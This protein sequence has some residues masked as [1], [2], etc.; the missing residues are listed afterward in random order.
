MNK[1]HTG[2]TLS[3]EDLRKWYQKME[4]E[5]ILSSYTFPAKPSSDGYYHVYLSDAGGRKQI[6][7]K[8]LEK[9]KE[10]VYEYE[11][12][13]I[14]STRKTFKDVF[15]TVQQEKLRYVKDPEK[16]ISVGNT[17]SVDRS[18]YNRFFNGTEF[19]NMYID[20]ISKSDIEKL[21]FTTLEQNDLKKKAFMSMRNILSSVFKLAFEQYWILDNPYKRIDFKKY[22]YMLARD[23]A[24]HLRVHSSEDVERMLDFLHE[25]QSKKPGYIPAYALE[26]QIIM[27]LRRGEVAPIMWSDISSNSIRI[28]K[29]QI[30][31]KTNKDLVIVYHT[32]TYKDRE[33]PITSDISDFIDRLRAACDRFYPAS[34]YLFPD[35]SQKNGVISNKVVYRLYERMCKKLDIEISREFTRGPHSFRRNGITRICNASGGN[36]YLASVLYGNSPQSASRHYYTGINLS[37]A[38]A[39]LEGNRKSNPRREEHTAS[40]KQDIRKGNHRVTKGN[41]KLG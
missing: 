8:N 5:Q 34:P 1:N 11:K 40:S 28:S 29:E 12:D 19:E 26:L 7:A 32:K 41:Q 36:I 24:V 21:C 6:K 33:F 37:E 4:K 3:L 13:V 17:L 10:K 23:T 2:G 25:K 39:L 18:N 30:T 20:D 16:L 38:K 31:D 14:G 15:E 9:L 27:G 22:N 35:D